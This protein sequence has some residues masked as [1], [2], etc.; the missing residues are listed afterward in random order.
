MCS[1]QLHYD[2]IEADEHHILCSTGPKAALLCEKIQH[3]IDS[4][5]LSIKGMISL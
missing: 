1:I 5:F 4:T 3:E 2:R